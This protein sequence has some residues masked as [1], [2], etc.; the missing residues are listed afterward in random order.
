MQK[1]TFYQQAPNCLRQ[2]MGE[3]VLLFNPETTSTIH[4]NQTADLIWQL[5]EE[6]SIESLIASLKA[7][8]P[9]QQSQIEQDVL[10]TVNSLVNQK[11]LLPVEKN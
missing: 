11:A 4:L 9:E 2:E 3:D 10:D 1:H 6:S 5:C 8:Y 7:Q